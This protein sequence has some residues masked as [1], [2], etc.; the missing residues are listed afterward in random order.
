MEIRIINSTD[1]AACPKQSLLPQHYHDDGTCKCAERDDAEA[2]V[3]AAQADL[4]EAQDVLA[5]AKRWLRST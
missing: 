2:A 3:Q 5:D 1:V 4:R